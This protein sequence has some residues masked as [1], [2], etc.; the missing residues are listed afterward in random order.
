[1]NRVG[2]ITVQI[3][4]ETIR[5]PDFIVDETE[6]IRRFYKWFPEIGSGNYVKVVVKSN[7]EPRLV[8]TAHPDESQ[9]MR[10]RET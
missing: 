6:Y 1:M 5:Q 4:Q 2:L 9:R 8:I 7:V 10:R 3:I